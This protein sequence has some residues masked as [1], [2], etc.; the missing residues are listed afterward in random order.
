MAN[1]G[2]WI[3]NPQGYQNIETLTGITFT[4]KNTYNIQ[5]IG[6]AYIR[7]G[8]IGKGILIEKSDP[9]D[10][11]PNTV[12]DIYI[13]AQHNNVILNIDESEQSEQSNQ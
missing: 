2:T 8:T 4:V 1:L 3:L 13:A 10:Y 9:F 7:R 5:I 12:E 6:K 11:T